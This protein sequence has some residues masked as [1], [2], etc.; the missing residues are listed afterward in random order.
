MNFWLK[1]IALLLVGAGIGSAV[2]GLGLFGSAQSAN[3]L[4]TSD[5]QGTTQGQQE[6]SFLEHLIEQHLVSVAMA[7]RVQQTTNRPELRN[8]SS[9]VIAIQSD[10]IEEMRDWLASWDFSSDLATGT[11]HTQGY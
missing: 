6:H 9:E 8:L 3:V 1:S 10:E 4:L 2:T 5:L 7:E 11:V